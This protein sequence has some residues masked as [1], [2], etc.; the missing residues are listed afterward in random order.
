MSNETFKRGL[1]VALYVPLAL[2]NGMIA[3]VVGVKLWVAPAPEFIAE[4]VSTTTDPRNLFIVTCTAA[5]VFTALLVLEF[6]H[7]QEPLWATHNARR[8]K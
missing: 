4:L 7:E 1:R 3:A 2:V 8:F 6:F 5:V